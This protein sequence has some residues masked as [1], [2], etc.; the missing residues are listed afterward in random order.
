MHYLSED[1]WP[2][3]GALG[4]IA[5]G[6]LVALRV[7]QQGKYLIRAG[8]A[9]GLALLVIG[10]ERAWVTDNERIEAVV[11]E[12]ATAVRTSDADRM[13]ACLTPDVIVD[14]G[15]AAS[16]LER[17]TFLRETLRFLG[18]FSGQKITLVLLRPALESLRFDF[19]SVG[20]LTTHAGALS[21][22]GTAEFR[23]FAGGTYHDPGSNIDY[24]FATPTS[25]SDWSL[26]LRETAPG[27]WKV[28]RITPTAFPTEGVTVRRRD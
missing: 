28:E 16:L 5:L 3:A 22:R 6:F 7:T 4:L 18:R 20:R 10:V 13:A 11:Y 23:V 14:V 2:L 26:G 21:R 9:L 1:P 17:G 25:G 27:V 24:N 12:L 15:N 8:I 19:L